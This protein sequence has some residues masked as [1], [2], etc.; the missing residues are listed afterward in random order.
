M[1]NAFLSKQIKFRGKLKIK[2]NGLDKS[3]HLKVILM[4]EQL[5]KAIQ[6]I[7]R[8]ANPDKII[9]F[10]SFPRGDYNQN[11]DYDICIIKKGVAHK[12]K[13][14]Q[15]IYKS[16]YGISAPIDLIVETPENF[17]KLKD[18]PYFIYKTIVEEGTLLYEKQKI[19]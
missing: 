11:S 13:L 19:S 5:E 7:I 9:L 16:L 6:I 14:A 4:N 17:A 3:V 8:V 10:G 2:K 12:R 1:K 15:M 18:N